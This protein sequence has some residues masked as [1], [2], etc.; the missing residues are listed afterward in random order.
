M[1]AG[2][3]PGAVGADLRAIETIGAVLSKGTTSSSEPPSAV[4][5]DPNP[6][7]PSANRFSAGREDA[8]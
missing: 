1:R 4:H 7:G 8:A 3:L 6:P 5:A 2:D